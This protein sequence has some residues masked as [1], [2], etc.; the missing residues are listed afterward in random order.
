MNKVVSKH[1]KYLIPNT[2]YPNSG[3]SLIEVLV[4]ITLLGLMVIPIL[5]S[6]NS[7][8]RKYR[9]LY[10]DSQAYLITQKN[11]EIATN[12][13]QSAA[14]WERIP[15]PTSPQTYAPPTFPDWQFHYTQQPV[16]IQGGY[17]TWLTFQPV[18]RDDQNEVIPY[19][20]DCQMDPYAVEVVSQTLW[21]DH[22]QSTIS[23]IFANLTVNPNSGD[24][25]DHKIW[26]CHVPPGN[27][28][29][30]HAVN[31]DLHAWINGHSPHNAHQYDFEITGSED[32][33]CG[34]AYLYISQN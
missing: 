7:L 11:L 23:T 22:Q 29:N 19:Q 31:I 5:L 25:G 16:E 24:P 17:R 4:V 13:V 1:T 6:L 14:T 32:P 8:N 28:E 18:C 12:I 21:G 34:Q 33:D 2:T 26:I 10:V 30:A 20:S 3:Q 27:P 15:R 9:Q